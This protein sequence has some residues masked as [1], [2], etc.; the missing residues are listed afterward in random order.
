[1]AEFKKQEKQEFKTIA[2]NVFDGD[3]RNVTLTI[4]K[5]QGEGQTSPNTYT[6]LLFPKNVF[7]DSE[8]VKL[9]STTFGL[10]D[11]KVEH[12]DKDELS[13]ILK[14]VE[15]FYTKH[16]DKIIVVPDPG[17]PEPPV[18]EKPT[19]PPVEGGTEDGGTN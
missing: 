13:D 17:E 8:I 5:F 18:E 10:L 11:D 2:E 1:M 3:Q 4:E 14:A 7:D 6:Q 15:V 9:V 12:L 19:D 16:K